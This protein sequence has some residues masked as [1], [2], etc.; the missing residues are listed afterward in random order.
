MRTID[1][2]HAPLFAACLALAACGGGSAPTPA[3]PAPPPA[4]LQTGDVHVLASAVDTMAL[5]ERVTRQ[6]GIPRGEQVWMLLVTVRRGETSAT[7][8]V[9]ARAQ[10]LE[11]NNIA[12]KMKA[13]PTATNY[14]DYIGTFS[15]AGPDTLRFTVDV[16]PEGAPSAQLTF[17]REIPR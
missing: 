6:Y 13:T 1:R 16:A 15:I 5:P 14:I 10:T 12:I 17:S 2:L 9:E 3:Q 11:G 7:A 8:K 4:E